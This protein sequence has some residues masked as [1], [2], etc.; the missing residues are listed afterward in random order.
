MSCQSRRKATAF[1]QEGQ[2]PACRVVAQSPERTLLEKALILHT[3][4]CK[5]R[6]PGQ[7]SRHAYDLAMMHMGGTTLTVT[8]ALYEEVAR[9]K[10][11]FA[12]DQHAGAAPSDGIRLLPEGEVHAA[13][14]ADYRNMAPMFFASP[15]APTWERVIA[16]LGALETALRAI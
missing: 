11:A 13:L 12:D 10:L 8:R 6:L 1:R 14:A 16:A 2:P 3:G 4:N 5:G 7:S 9:H 15:V